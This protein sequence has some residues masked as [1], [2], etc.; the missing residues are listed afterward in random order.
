MFPGFEKQKEQNR[1]VKKI[2][3]EISLKSWYIFSGLVIVWIREE[4][5]G[6]YIL[7]MI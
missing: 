6:E 4:L 3:M 5:K 7:S 2:D 1:E